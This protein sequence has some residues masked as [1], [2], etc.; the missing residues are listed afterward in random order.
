MGVDL[1]G[2][3][4]RAGAVTVD[5]RLTA[6]TEVLTEPTRGSAAVLDTVQEAIARLAGSLDR[7]TAIGVAAA[8]LIHP[9]TGAVVAAP[10][11]GWRGVPLAAILAARFG[12]PVSVENDVRAAAWGEFRFGVHR[13]R[14]LIAVFVGTGIGSGVILD[15]AL[16][17]GSGN[18]A[19]ELGHTQVV[20]DGLPCPCGGHGCLEQYASGAGV[21]R[22][23]RAALADGART[24]LGDETGGDAAALTVDMLAAAANSGDELARRLW[25]E[26]RR[27]FTL[28]VANYVTL[29]N[30]ELLILGGG[31]M[32]NVPELFDDV[33]G[34]VLLATTILARDSLRI[35]HARLG[36]WGGVLGAADLAAHGGPEM[37]LKPP[38][39]RAAAAEPRRPSS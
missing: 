23:L 25:T 13:A 28:A 24:A 7:L 9:D 15:G 3:R 17:S 35:E 26:L 31:V 8:G 16:W 22:R 36:D 11:L 10:N 20:P 21:Q 34:G 27:Y 29:L 33:T 6:Q 38:D 2:T 12:V 19:G 5:G 14:S 37:A 18:S 39:V 1:G 30:P 32:D 4:V